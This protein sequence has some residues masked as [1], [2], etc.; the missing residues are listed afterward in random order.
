MQ[1][2]VRVLAAAAVDCDLP[3]WRERE[4]FGNKDKPLHPLDVTSFEP[5]EENVAAIENNPQVSTASAD[6]LCQIMTALLR[7][8]NLHPVLQALANALKE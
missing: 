7:E 5:Y 3:P 1:L 2:A 8:H 6:E 4:P